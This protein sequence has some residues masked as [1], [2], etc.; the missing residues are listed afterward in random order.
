ML[1]IDCKREY[2]IYMLVYFI[3]RGCFLKFITYKNSG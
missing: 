1:D 3:E 2:Y